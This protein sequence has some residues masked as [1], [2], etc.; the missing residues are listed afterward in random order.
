MKK[1]LLA[2]VI[3]SSCTT[4][5]TVFEGSARPTENGR[6]ISSSSL[7]NEEIDRLWVKVNNRKDSLIRSN[8][9]HFWAWMR[10]NSPQQ[11]KKVLNYEGQITADPHYFN[12]A[13]IHSEDKGG[14]ALVDVDDS[15]MGSFYLD[16]VR[17]AVFVKAYMK[18][19]FTS[20]LLKSY[21]DGLQHK[22]MKVPDVLKKTMRK[23]RKDLEL[24]NASWVQKNLESDYKLNNKSLGIKGFKSISLAKSKIGD[25]LKDSLL[26]EKKAKLIYD[27]GYV[28]N[29]SG[30]SRGMGRYWF[31]IVDTESDRNKIIECKQLSEPATAFYTSQKQHKERIE[32]V[33]KY[34]SDFPTK[35]SYVFNIPDYSF[36]CR[37]KHF[38]FFE[39][40]DVEKGMKTKEMLEYSQ[41]I[42][43]WIGLKQSDQPKSGA[44]V[45]ELSANKELALKTTVELIRTYENHVFRLD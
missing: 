38:Q 1:Q 16:F 34:F 12:F 45:K 28:E 11:L 4:Q 39:R 36:W 25:D 19:D 30:S 20:E 42:A 40:D 3:L 37:P 31:S 26:K 43:Y 21:I 2:F 5:V 15:G 29:D 44:Y 41:Y 35:D 22:D 32:N 24:E 10:K 14:L 8:P 33:L 17:Y 18:N 27:S 6:S 9:T 7:T 23:S 13:D